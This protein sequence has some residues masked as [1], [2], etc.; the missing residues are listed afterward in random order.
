MSQS[1]LVLFEIEARDRASAVFKDLEGSLGNVSKALEVLRGKADQTGA[2][3][4]T[5]KARVDALKR[6]HDEAKVAVQN[7]GV[8]IVAAGQKVADAQKK[9]ADAAKLSGADQEKAAA[10]ASAALKAATGEEQAALSKLQG[11]IDAAS[12]AHGDLTK[13]QSD[14]K[15]KSSQVAE[16]LKGVGIASGAV[17]A[18]VGIAA[19][20]S[21][22]AAATWQEGMTQLQTGAGEAAA[23]LPLVSDGMLKIARDTGTASDA[24]Q[25]GGYLIESAGFHG[26]D[27]L[28]VL[29]A[30][31]EGAKVG[32]ADLQTVAD[33][34]TSALNAYGMQAGDATKITDEMV[35]TVGAGKM[36]MQDLTGSL[37]AV[38]PI[39]AAAG[40]GFDQVGGAVAT[41]TAQGMSAQQATQDLNH[42][43]SSLQNPNSVAVA[44]MEQ[45]GLSANDVS[46]NLGKR[47]LTGTM[48]L[49]T[50]TILQH[51]GPAGTVLMDS[52]N[53]SKSAASDAQTMLDKM[54]PSMQKIAKGFMDGTVTLGDWRKDLKAL[55][56]DQANLATQFAA[57][58]DKAHGFNDELKKGGPAA[59]TYNATLSKIMGGQ[60][61]LD[62]A[63]LLSGTHA[64][65]FNENVKAIGDAAKGASGDVTGW[66][67]VQED[68]NT[69]M[70]KAKQ[71]FDTVKIAIGSA[72]LPVLSDLMDKVSGFLGPVVDW[73]SHNKELVAGILITVGAIGAL[74][75]I[76][77]IL[78]IAFTFLAANPIVLI[79]TGIIIAVAALAAGIYFLV[80]HWQEVWGAIVSFT[81]P[82]VDWIVGAARNVAD[83][84]VAAFR[85][86]SGFLAPILAA[87]STAVANF[88]AGFIQ[89]WQVAVAILREIWDVIV[90]VLK[91]AI[92]IIY[93]VVVTPIV[94]YVK[95]MAAIFTWLWQ[96]A[97]KPAW[98]GIVDVM[99]I[100]WAFILTNVINPI[101]A[102]VKLVASVYIW[103]WQ[104]VV[105]PVWQGI[106]NAISV[107]WQWLLANVINP[108]VNYVK[109][110]AST[111]T[112]FWQNVIVPVW[113]GI[114]NAISTAWNWLYS[115]VVLGIQLEI[116]GLGI[117][118]NWLHDS[119][120][121]PV[122]DA[123]QTAIG[124]AW[125][126][127]SHNVF[128]PI[129]KA[130]DLMGKGF[131]TARD[132]IAKAWGEIQDAAKAPVAFIVNTVYTNGIK[133]V[134]DDIATKVGLQPLPTL[135]FAK[136]G[137]VPGYSPGNDIVHA[138]LSPG[139]GI[140]V[141][142]AVRALGGAAGIDAINSMYGGGS[143]KSPG[144]HFAGGG[145]VGDI[146]GS[147]GNAIGGALN[148]LK[149]AAL[150]GLQTAATPLVH[151]FE[152]LADN[153]PGSGTGFGAMLDKGVHTLGDG[154][155]SWIGGKD[156]AANDAKAAAGGSVG[157]PGAVS[158][159][160]AGWVQA[161]MAAANVAGSNW[162][163]GL[164]TIIMH[165]SGGNPNATN[166]WDSNAAAGDPSRGLM[167][168]IMSTFEAYRS[169]GLPDDIF[170]PVANIVAG[171]GYIKS[172][173]GDIGNVP[174]LV[175]MAQGGP[176]VGYD[177][178]GYLEPGFTPVWNGTGHREIVSPNG[179]GQFS[180]GGGD[181]HVTLN[182]NAF[183]SIDQ[184]F[185]RRF[186]DEW[187]R[188]FVTRV[189][190]Q[191]GVQIRR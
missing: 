190:P 15:A 44:Q 123:I 81:K 8:D 119:V 54:P 134:W 69:K 59:E 159:D 53:Q 185:L 165:E 174:G 21:V 1:E 80:T 18:G 55:P 97:L 148:V 36:H 110:V 49:I 3:L 31:A 91:V 145:V 94:L 33:G 32:G 58:V 29:R 153:M 28:L 79:I 100:A 141:P 78:T 115:N 73:I 106:Q 38:L 138:M 41:M 96:N 46:Q 154:F 180:G 133:A 12:K 66:A 6:A 132:I 126:W 98:D 114:Q 112:W 125:D 89:V 171:I 178:G 161:A 37:S 65:T 43:I 84:F 72:L 131:E 61:G 92:A 173:Y 7:A 70:D 26:A 67:E 160:L 189:L 166:N 147:I 150:G 105:V 156:K 60:T 22:K 19:V 107:V 162:V 5:A 151:G 74:V 90:T 34:V 86:I 155:L 169:Q 47:G 146:L 20:E 93:T 17:A 99:R 149:D 182:V 57:V 188:D 24:V 25:K 63:L 168:T 95:L 35:A 170:D 39:A 135:N 71:A 152:S 143:G 136:G 51:M 11:S 179:V 85:N 52:F 10:E 56:A 23:N 164:E 103:L 82:A 64:A 144:N 77:S 87:I 62:T 172:R 40:I 76:V 111:F 158:G 137:T 30:A 121:K 116:K 108:I 75:A 101:I 129:G 183:G 124:D 13:A 45:L 14:L 68:F 2:N 191:A 142:Q 83:F 127:I 120:I 102:Y 130:V 167:Q 113:L 16:A 118:F 109:L 50:S 9:V 48:D 88:I 177:S 104:N 157:S 128:D 187:G 140:L 27:G 42:T 181:V 176:Y 122:W 117:I 175:S 139:E 4:D 186:G 163:N 184:A